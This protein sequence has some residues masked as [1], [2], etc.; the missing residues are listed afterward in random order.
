MTGSQIHVTQDSLKTAIGA[1]KITSQTCLPPDFFEESVC[2]CSP[3]V[4]EN[5]IGE[6]CIL[7]DLRSLTVSLFNTSVMLYRIL[8]QL[9]TW[10]KKQSGQS[11]SNFN[12]TA[13][14]SSTRKRKT[15]NRS[16]KYTGRAAVLIITHALH[17]VTNSAAAENFPEGRTCWLSELHPLP[18]GNNLPNSEVLLLFKAILQGPATHLCRRVEV[19]SV[20]I[21][22]SQCRS[23]DEKLLS[24]YLG[25]PQM[26]LSTEG[27]PIATEDR[28]NILCNSSL[29]QAELFSALLLQQRN[30]AF[31]TE[32]RQ[33]GSLGPSLRSFHPTRGRPRCA[34]KMNYYWLR[35]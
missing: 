1:I 8:R 13:V 12:S 20:S 9:L 18:S 22:A 6:G 5:D 7:S 34:K 21:V 24:W 27:G 25:N 19:P 32:F 14:L 26:L 16:E 17:C 33:V 2:G 10:F 31:A 4:F 11:N 30:R 28:N 29:L 3:R 35:S 23:G 15:A